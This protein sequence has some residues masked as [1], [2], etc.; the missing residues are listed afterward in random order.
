L[1][2]KFVAILFCILI[3]SCNSPFNPTN[4]DELLSFPEQIEINGRI[5][6]LESF[7]WRDFMPGP[8]AYPDGRPLIALIWV[9]AV[10]L[11]QFPSNLDAN[12]LWIINGQEV[13]ETEFSYEERPQDPN[14]KHQKEKIA[15]DGPKWGPD[16]YVD[17]VVKIIDSNNRVYFLKASNQ[18]IGRTD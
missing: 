15:R 8:D 11:L 5:Y 10:D 7:L 4:I 13:W 9:T 6:T 16:I 18:Y 17:V 1:I 14:R 2:K 12:R 3:F